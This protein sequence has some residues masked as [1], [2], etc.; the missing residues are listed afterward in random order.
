MNR[1]AH[2]ALRLNPITQGIKQHLQSQRVQ[3]FATALIASSVAFAPAETSAGPILEEIIVTAQKREMN[4]Q[5]VPISLQ[6]LDTAKLTA[7]GIS[8]FKDY[9]LQLPSVSYKTQG[10]GLNN[11]YMRGVSDGGDGNQSGAAPSV[12]VY[13]D[14]QPVTSIASS[15]D[16][17]IYDIARIEALA[18]PQGSLFGASSQAGTLRIISN[19]PK[20]GVTE[21]RIDIGGMFTEEGDPSNNQEGM[22]NIPLGD[23]AALRLVG[24]RIDEGGYIDNVAG[25]RTYNTDTS[26]SVYNGGVAAIVP[27][28]TRTATTDNRTSVS[29]D[30]RGTIARPAEDINE[31]EKYGIRALLKVDLNDN[32]SATAGIFYQNMKTEGVWDHD[33]DSLGVDGNP[34]GDYN[35]QRFYEDSKQDEFIQYSLVLKGNI[36]DVVELTYAGSYLDRTVDYVNDYTEYAIAQTYVPYYVCDGTSVGPVNNTDCTS[37][38]QF[39]VENEQMTRQTHELRITSLGDGPISYTLGVF[40]NEFK[41][42]FTLEYVQPGMSPSL[43][44]NIPGTDGTNLHYMTDQVRIDRQKAVFGEITYAFNDQWSV[45]FGGRWYETQQELVGFAT[46]GPA[47]FGGT[48][49]GNP[50]YEVDDSDFLKKFNL[51]WRMNDDAMLYVTR[52]EGFRPGGVN[53][54]ESL[55]RFNALIY[56]SD[57]VTSYEGGFKTTWMDGRLRFNGALYVLSWEDMLYTIYD[58]SLSPCCGSTYNLGDAETKGVELDVTFAATEALTLTGA[59]SYISAKTVE[60]LLLPNTTLVVPKGQRLPNVPRWKGNMTARYEFT[61]GNYDAF[62]EMTYIYYD[63][64]T[65]RI[66]PADV[67]FNTQDDYSLINLRAGMSMGPWNVTAF[68]DNATDKIADISVDARVYGTSTQINRPRSFGVKVGYSFY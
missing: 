50:N 65:N 48:I 67:L 58:Y 60:D 12:G 39:V 52:S 53:R 55:Q 43:I 59:M 15:L 44:V 54:D 45:T 38:D 23:K 68:L 40:W 27:G 6:A 36:N 2:Q 32:W 7:L 3:V 33:P 19:Q 29:G 20:M 34:I 25:T 41:N 24:W 21:A 13:L 16:V 18:G 42:D 51:T 26:V 1:Q 31:L 37:L 14:E 28:V 10:P 5:D 56:H 66:R 30:P 35:I 47:A 22:I 57:F 11:I 62:A 49:G 46:F 8:D 63:D 9:V 4:I 17:H 61:V 64:T